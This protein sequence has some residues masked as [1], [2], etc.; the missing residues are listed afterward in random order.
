M[1]K[2][3]ASYSTLPKNDRNR[4]ELIDAAEYLKGLFDGIERKEVL[5]VDASD[6]DFCRYLKGNSQGEKVRIIGG[7]KYGSGQNKMIMKSL[8]VLA[9]N[10]GLRKAMHGEDFKFMVSANESFDRSNVNFWLKGKSAK[11]ILE[12]NNMTNKVKLRYP[13]TGVLK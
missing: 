5:W 2:Y 8:V 13:I 10:N 12:I 1:K 3:G 9:E 11:K 7:Y 6:K 4:L